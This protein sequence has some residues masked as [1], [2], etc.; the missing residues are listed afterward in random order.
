M[1]EVSISQKGVSVFFFKKKILIVDDDVTAR[2]MMGIRFQ[3]LDQYKVLTAKS[4]AE[5]IEIA[6]KE[7]PHII[8]V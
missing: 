4:G 8:E 2:K 3:K 1:Y 7:T 6:Q 5:G